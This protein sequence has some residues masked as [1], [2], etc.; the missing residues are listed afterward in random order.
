MDCRRV[1][2]HWLIVV[3]WCLTFS[4]QCVVMSSACVVFLLRGQA[5]RCESSHPPWVLS[6]A[7]GSGGT[8][9]EESSPVA[10]PRA[11]SRARAAARCPMARL[12]RGHPAHVRASSWSD[13]RG[14]AHPGGLKAP[15]VRWAACVGQDPPQVSGLL[16]MRAHSMGLLGALAP[17]TAAAAFRARL[18]AQLFSRWVSGAS[19]DSRIA[20]TCIS[21][22]DSLLPRGCR[23]RRRSRALRRRSRVSEHGVVAVIHIR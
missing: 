13:R 16:L 8:S 18:L 22:A 10:Y 5:A 11:A 17:A 14:V 23:Q 1:E 12:C 21:H 9:S 3:M 2:M 20:F 4:C 15:R 19:V 7:A 6:G